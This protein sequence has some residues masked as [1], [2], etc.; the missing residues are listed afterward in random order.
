MLSLKRNAVKCLV[1][2]DIIESTYTH[3]FKYCKCGQT[4]VDGGLDYQRYGSMDMDN[5][6]SLAEF[7]ECVACGADIEY[8]SSYVH[9]FP[10]YG[11]VCVGCIEERTRGGQLLPDPED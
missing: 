3:D 4:M 8:R 7:H 2:E 6:V 5:V 10:P 9:D 1:C 11:W